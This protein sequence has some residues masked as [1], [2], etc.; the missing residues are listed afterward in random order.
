MYPN[1]DFWFENIPSGNTGPNTGLTFLP[2][3]GI[4]GGPQ[5][6]DLSARVNPP[7]LFWTVVVNLGF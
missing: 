6:K 4:L 2:G 7:C 5:K 1:L 3:L